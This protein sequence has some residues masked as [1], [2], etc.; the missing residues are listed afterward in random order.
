MLGYI[1]EDVRSG[2]LRWPDLTPPEWQEASSRAIAL[3]QATGRF[4]VFEKEYFR[5]DGSRVPVLLAG[6]AV[7]DARQELWCS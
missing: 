5:S 6:A 2:R 1:A 3:L 7:D 4:D